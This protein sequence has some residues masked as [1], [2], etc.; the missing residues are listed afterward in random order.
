MINYGDFHVVMDDPNSW[1][2]D[3]HGKSEI[4]S[5]ISAFGEAP[6]FLIAKLTPKTWLTFGFMGRCIDSFVT[7]GAHLAAI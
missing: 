3:F 4:T 5:P 7:A 1:L 2:D 6:V